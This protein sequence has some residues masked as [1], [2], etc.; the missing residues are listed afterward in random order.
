MIGWQLYISNFQSRNWFAEIANQYLSPNIYACEKKEKEKRN[1]SLILLSINTVDKTRQG[2]A[3]TLMHVQLFNLYNY[4]H[5]WFDDDVVHTGVHCEAWTIIVNVHLVGSSSLFR[6]AHVAGFI[7]FNNNNL[8]KRKGHHDDCN[9]HS[10]LELKKL[11]YNHHISSKSECQNMFCS[12]LHS[13]NF[14]E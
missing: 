1:I 11:K 5:A 6:W 7:C 14:T 8:Q 3:I 9:F 2:V 12:I 10:Q 4:Y 13:V